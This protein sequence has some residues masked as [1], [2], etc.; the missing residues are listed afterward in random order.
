MRHLTLATAIAF[1]TALLLSPAVMAHPGTVDEIIGEIDFSKVGEADQAQVKEVVARMIY[2]CPG[3]VWW[4]GD[5]KPGSAN[6]KLSHFDD[7]LMTGYGEPLDWR[8]EVRL[9]VVMVDRPSN[10]WP[11]DTARNHMR[12]IAGGGIRP[13]IFGDKET[14]NLICGTMPSVS[15][16]GFVDVPVLGVI[17]HYWPPID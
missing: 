6:A 16:M 10:P 13:G 5:V 9:E 14:T 7:D 2:A 15:G 8:T 12:F 1:I 4:W 17:N 11:G 3:L